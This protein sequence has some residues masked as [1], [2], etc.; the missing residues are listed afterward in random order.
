MF[1]FLYNR[2]VKEAGAT[3]AFVLFFSLE[4]DDLSPQP[5]QPSA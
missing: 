4:P 1:N 3:D 2:T 5:G